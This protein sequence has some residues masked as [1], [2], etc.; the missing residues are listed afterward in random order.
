MQHHKPN[1]GK[2][3][4]IPANPEV[5]LTLEGSAIL[6][7]MFRVRWE[8]WNELE[9]ERRR[10][11]TEEAAG[12]L[13]SL[14]SSGTAAY[15]L[16]GHK[17]DLMLVHFRRNFEE[18]NATE[19]RLAQLG[20]WRYLEPTG[21]YVSVVELGLYESTVKLLDSLAE[22][23]VSPGS[24]EWVR[25]M[26]ETL[27]RQRGAMAPRLEPEIP[28]ARYLCFYPMDRRRGESKN[29][30]RLPIRERQRMMAE[31][32][33]VGRKY[34]GA[35]KQIISGSIGFD[36]WEWGVDLFA[37]DPL[38]FKKLIYEMRFDEA[39]AD[40]AVFGPF[41]V[42]IRFLAQQLPVFLSG[43]LPER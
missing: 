41:W 30:Y 42:G 19:L 39:S 37:E 24:E 22:R 27:E 7:Q 14:E 21:S 9:E 35:V 36:D 43:R 29:W 32:G 38:I 1:E 20:L 10:A 4:G 6:H 34:A 23:G 28:P 11:I 33:L 25:A 3:P 15:S 31:H 2:N 16:L 18:L 13:A 26:E 8:A 12:T 5:P 40:Y 17:G